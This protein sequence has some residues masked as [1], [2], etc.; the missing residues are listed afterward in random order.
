[1]QLLLPKPAVV[2]VVIG[3]ATVVAQSPASVVPVAGVA[4]GVHHVNAVAQQFTN[5]R[6]GSGY[7][8]GGRDIGHRFSA[9]LKAAHLVASRSNTV[10]DYGTSFR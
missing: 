8:V 10:E 6:R 4:A 7:H 3:L 1:M 9:W 2:V 5:G